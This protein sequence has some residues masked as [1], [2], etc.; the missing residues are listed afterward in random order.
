M[1]TKYK[2]HYKAGEQVFNCYGRRSNRFLLL[3]Y[4]FSLRNNKYNSFPFRVWLD[5]PDTE[6]PSQEEEESKSEKKSSPGGEEEE[7]DRPS[8]MLRLKSTRLCSEL[9]VY[10][11]NNLLNKYKGANS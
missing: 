7:E 2:G 11:R 1:T 5:V 9:L 6:T 10:L 3:N 8:R 4:G